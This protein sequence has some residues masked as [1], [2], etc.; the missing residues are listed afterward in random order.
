MPGRIAVNKLE[1]DLWHAN[2]AIWGWETDRVAIPSHAAA[3]G[4]CSGVRRG[5]GRGWRAL[6]AGVGHTASP[7]LLLQ[8]RPGLLWQP[9]QL[10][11]GPLGLSEAQQ[12][13]QPHPTCVSAGASSSSML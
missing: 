8:G 12:S 1:V 13:C 4:S 11:I 2:R 7:K 5:Q 3:Q 10:R 6:W 9:L